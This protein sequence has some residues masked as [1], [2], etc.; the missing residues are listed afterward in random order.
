MSRITAVKYELPYIMRTHLFLFFGFSLK[1][2]LGCRGIR[3]NLLVKDKKVSL[4]SYFIFF[5]KLKFST[6]SSTVLDYRDNLG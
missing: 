1:C 4:K 6:K 2:T 5:I 3:F